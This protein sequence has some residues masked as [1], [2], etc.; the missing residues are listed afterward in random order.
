MLLFLALFQ[1]VVRI[2]NQAS[3]PRKL[4]SVGITSELALLTTT[5]L[6]A[7]AVHEPVTAAGFAVVVTILLSGRNRIHRFV[8]EILT[9]QEVHAALL[10]SDLRL[11]CCL[12]HRTVPLDHF[13]Y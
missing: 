5:L 9:E 3:N 10:F 13:R 4:A 12:S 8:R 1:L 11:L 2:G 6:G 7:L